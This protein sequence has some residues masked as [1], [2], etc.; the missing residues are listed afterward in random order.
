MPGQVARNRSSHRL[1]LTATHLAPVEFVLLQV[2][3]EESRFTYEV[4]DRDSH[5]FQFRKRE[6]FR[7]ILFPHHPVH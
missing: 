7:V 5:G 4:L 3:P 1:I 2:N 6:V